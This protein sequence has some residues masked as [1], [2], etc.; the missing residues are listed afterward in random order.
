MTERIGSTPYIFRG[1]KVSP[2][3]REI[4]V[5]TAVGLPSRQIAIQLSISPQTVKNHRSNAYI[6]LDV[7]SAVQAVTLLMATD[8]EFYDE[9][10]QSI[11]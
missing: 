8:Q 3:E 9:V 4:L 2:R 1:R 11:T 5:L 7:Y 10:K 6:K